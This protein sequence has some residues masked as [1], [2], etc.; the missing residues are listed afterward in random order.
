MLESEGQFLVTLGVRSAPE[1]EKAGVEGLW[2]IFFTHPRRLVGSYGGSKAKGS[3]LQ[4]LVL[5]PFSK[6]DV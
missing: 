6:E 5:P 1:E 3:F 4:L 2:L